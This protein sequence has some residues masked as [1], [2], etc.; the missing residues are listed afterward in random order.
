LRSQ[1]PSVI[2]APDNTGHPREQSKEFSEKVGK[3]V[4]IIPR[5]VGKTLSGKKAFIALGLTAGN[6]TAPR[7]CQSRCA[8]SG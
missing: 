8:G 5:L 6:K 4:G 2:P 7:I 1:Q 3:I